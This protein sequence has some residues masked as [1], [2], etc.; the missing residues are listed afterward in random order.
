V[1]AGADYSKVMS[2]TGEFDPV[3]T[4]YRG[5]T[6]SEAKSSAIFL[7]DNAEVAKSYMQNSGQVMKY[8]LSNAGLQITSTRNTKVSYQ[9]VKI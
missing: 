5:T 9:S 8:E 2:A 7:T 3:K 6:G 4:L 1:T